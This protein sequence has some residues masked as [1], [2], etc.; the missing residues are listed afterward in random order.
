MLAVDGEP[1][2]ARRRDVS[3]GAVEAVSAGVHE[4][5]WEIP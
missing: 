3:D 1:H 5:L 2:A 4:I